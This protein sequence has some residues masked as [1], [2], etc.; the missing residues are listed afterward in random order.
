MVLCQRRSMRTFAK[1]L[2][3][4]TTTLD[5]E[6]SA[7]IGNVK[8]S[9]RDMEGI[10]PD[11]QRQILASSVDGVALSDLNYQAVLRLRGGMQIF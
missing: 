3:G 10:P 11:Q 5:A 9:V 7:T 4:M 8:A 1:V 6:A 2:S